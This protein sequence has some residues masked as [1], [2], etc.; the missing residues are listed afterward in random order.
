MKFK[1][2]LETLFSSKISGLWVL[3]KNQEISQDF[4][5]SFQN[6]EKYTY[7]VIV[8]I[9]IFSKSSDDLGGALQFIWSGCLDRK[10]NVDRP[11]EIRWSIV[12]PSDCKTQPKDYWGLRIPSSFLIRSLF[13]RQTCIIHTHTGSFGFSGF[14]WI[15]KL[16]RKSLEINRAIDT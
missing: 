6:R 10:E 9:P 4:R 15:R 12:Q 3:G 5:K 14:Y 1:V 11:K 13:Q 8:L 7:N 16:Y 2:S